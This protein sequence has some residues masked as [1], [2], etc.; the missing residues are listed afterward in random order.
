MK[1]LVI[2]ALAAVLF[3]VS[4]MAAADPG[5]AAKGDKKECAA[6][7][8]DGKAY[9]T[10]RPRRP[11]PPSPEPPRPEGPLDMKDRG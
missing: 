5:D 6:C 3:G 8:K 9:G 7:C 1:K 10:A 2:P 4:L 11:R